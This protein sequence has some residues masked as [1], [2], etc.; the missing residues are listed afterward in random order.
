M[1]VF[2]VSNE[3]LKEVGMEGLVLLDKVAEEQEKGKGKG[4]GKEHGEA[5][6]GNDEGAKGESGK[7]NGGAR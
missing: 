7:E 1:A 6:K 4:E 5:E 3:I 2:L